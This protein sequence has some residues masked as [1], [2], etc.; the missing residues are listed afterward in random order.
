MERLP[1]VPGTEWSRPN[2]AHGGTLENGWRVNVHSS[3]GG[4]SYPA[5]TPTLEIQ[6]SSGKKK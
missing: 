6:D 2:G 3:G 1:V 4:E 5:G